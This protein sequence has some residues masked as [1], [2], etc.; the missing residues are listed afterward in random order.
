MIDLATY[1]MWEHYVVHWSGKRDIMTLSRSPDDEKLRRWVDKWYRI[2]F[3][4]R[5]PYE[6][7]ALF[8]LE[9]IL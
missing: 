7:H 4:L 6:G 5:R 3:E 9:R 2:Y 1:G 8:G